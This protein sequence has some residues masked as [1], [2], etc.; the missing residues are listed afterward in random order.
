MRDIDLFTT[1]CAVGED[2][3]WADQGDRSIGFFQE[4]FDLQE[5]TAVTELRAETLSRVLPHTQLADRCKVVKDRLEVRGQ[6]GTYQIHLGWSGA[7]LLTDSGNRWLRIPQKLLDA[8]RIELSG[9]PVDVDYRTE[10]T[11]R[12]ACVLA[13]DWKIEDPDLIKQLMP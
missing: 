6:L 9:V 3:T 11:L 7:M 8:V 13:E 10:T 4:R 1:V 5:L 2:E 12:K